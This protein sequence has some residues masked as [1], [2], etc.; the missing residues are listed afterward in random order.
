[1]SKITMFNAN[2]SGSF[3]QHFIRLLSR[4]WNELTGIAATDTEIVLTLEGSDDVLTITGSGFIVDG[5]GRLF[6]GTV[7][8][9]RMVDGGKPYF[10]IRD[11]AIAVSDFAAVFDDGNK[12]D[13]A[14]L[15]GPMTI[16]GSLGGDSDS[17]DDI[18]FGSSGDD[19]MH[20][21]SG[22]DVL[23]GNDGADLLDG[24]DNLDAAG[25]MYGGGVTAS[26]FD[27]SRN[28]GD[29]Q[30]DRYRDI[31]GLLGSEFKDD[32]QGD[33]RRN[34]IAGIGGNDIISGLGGHDLLGGGKGADI[35]IGG[36]SADMLFG[37][38]GRDIFVYTALADSGVDRR[39]RD[40]IADFNGQGMDRIDL[41]KLD[42]VAGGSDDGFAFIGGEEFTALG[43]VRVSLKGGDTL[44]ELNI[45]GNKA[46]DMAILLK[47]IRPAEIGEADFIL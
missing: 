8:G 13:I 27:P 9:V 21:K 29:A 36:A 20:A 11:I 19:V 10:G 1:M 34:V 40:E 2:D 15:F 41:R 37:E 24:G 6:G 14:D 42:A 28:T 44:I 46:A 35:L 33:Q 12:Q 16:F 31:E 30:G 18:L 4:A 39:G 38:G 22:S 23:T 7:T 5:D 26:L 45:A 25:Y 32:L 43:Q 17:G 3:Q 47:D